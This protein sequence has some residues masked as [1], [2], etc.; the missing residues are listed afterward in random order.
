MGGEIKPIQLS[1]SG[2]ASR[3]QENVFRE[4][5]KGC[6]TLRAYGFQEV[7]GYVG[8]QAVLGIGGYWENEGPIEQFV[9]QSYGGT[10][11]GLLLHTQQDGGIVQREVGDRQQCPVASDMNEL[12]L[13]LSGDDVEF[14]RLLRERADRLEEEAD[15]ESQTAYLSMRGRADNLRWVAEVM[16]K[17]LVYRSV[18]NKK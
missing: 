7:V 11:D 9:V 1:S 2:L 4:L 16:E 18:R 12:L 14:V 6:E 5:L 3:L 17:R 15:G 13:T 10:K 8:R